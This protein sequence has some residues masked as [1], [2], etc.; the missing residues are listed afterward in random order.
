MKDWAVDI[1]TL[2]PLM[3][4]FHFIDVG[5]LRRLLRMLAS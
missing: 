1:D 4:Q 2:D 3:L 5:K